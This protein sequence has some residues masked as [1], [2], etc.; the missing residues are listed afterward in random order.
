MAKTIISAYQIQGPRV[1]QED[2]YFVSDNVLA[3]LDGHGGQRCANYCKNRLLAL[4]KMFTWEKPEQ[5]LASICATLAQECRDM[6]S[7][8]ALSI[9]YIA[10]DSAIVAI[11][12]D[13]PVIIIDADGV[14]NISPEHNVRSNY[15]EARAAVER[16]GFISGGYLYN[17]SGSG[18]QMSRALG[19]RAL[20]DIIST[21]PEIYCVALGPKSVVLVASDGVIDPS[22][23]TLDA[24]AT[25]ATLLRDGVDA[26]SII[27]SIHQLA[28]NAT[29]IVWRRVD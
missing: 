4:T 13:A 17:S 28:D 6:Q 20:A 21:V 18:L 23:R 14:T 7:G 27:N 16:G 5:C 1:Y 12:G 15:K 22:H 29:A 2:F 10:D 9:V 19:D 24:H 3:V 25:I 26:R 11:L 8:A